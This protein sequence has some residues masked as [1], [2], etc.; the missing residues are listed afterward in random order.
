M[1]VVVIDF[2]DGGKTLEALVAEV[3]PELRERLAVAL[4]KHVGA[5][6]PAN[7]DE[8][9]ALRAVR[10]DLGPRRVAHHAARGE[11][12]AAVREAIRLGMATPGPEANLVWPHPR[13][14][15]ARI[16]RF[17][18]A[19]LADAAT[20]QRRIE[21]QLADGTKLGDAPPAPAL[22]DEGDL[23]GDLDR[24]LKPAN[25]EPPALLPPGPSESPTPVTPLPLEPGEPA[26][27]KA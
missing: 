24:D 13:S 15:E 5:P 26:P 2:T 12:K 4:A 6:A 20:L 1:Q 23:E 3:G 9:V 10:G 21:V 22:E 25:T 14:A 8:L 17:L 27:D 7:L 18:A 16:R 19:E 11:L